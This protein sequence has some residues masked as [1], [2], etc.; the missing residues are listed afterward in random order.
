MHRARTPR[1]RAAW[2][3]LLGVLRTELLFVVALV[4][5][6]GVRVL[7][8]YAFP[9]AFVFSDGPAYLAFADDLQPSVDRPVG[10]S[11]FLKAIADVDR[12][13]DVVALL[14]H[15]IGLATAVIVYAVLRRRGVRPWVA[16]LATLPLLFDALQ[17]ALEHSVL[18]DVLFM[19]LLVVALAVLLW[20]ST[21]SLWASVVVGLLFGMAT[22]VR[23]VG[24]PVVLIV[25]VFLLCVL[26][27]A[28]QRILHMAVLAAVFLT[29]VV[30]YAGWYHHDHGAWSLTQSGGRSLYMRTTSFVDCDKVELPSYERTLCPISKPDDRG[31][32]TFYGFHAPYTIPRLRP[33]AGMTKDQVEHDFAMRAIRTQP[34]DY[35][36]IVVRDFVAPFRRN[37]RLDFVEY[38]T[39]KKWSFYYWVDYRPTAHTGP[40]YAAHGGEMPS[41]RQPAG[42]WMADYGRHV[43]VRGLMFLALVLVAVAGLVVRRR[44]VPGRAAIF[45]CL[46]LALGLILEPDVTAEFTWRYQLPLLA[47]VPMAAAL[48]TTRLFGRARE[49]PAG[50]EPKTATPDRAR[51]TEPV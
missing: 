51:T 9:P 25:A 16:T 23:V 28:R 13:V 27:T 7:V 3:W 18:S 48:A 45:L 50:A 14:Q 37:D 21:P 22:V 29:P 8:V 47:L 34:G 1:A 43:F 35:L 11:M 17:L 5:G 20:R 10:Y 15:V 32:P 19:F 36:R 26:S 6:I 46:A 40:A 12:G 38:S 2:A 30:A 42:D 33:P 31:D 4:A 49:V 39:A 24:G 41:T 44:G